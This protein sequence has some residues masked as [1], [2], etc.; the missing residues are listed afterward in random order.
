MRVL[1]KPATAFSQVGSKLRILGHAHSELDTQ[2]R[3]CF[4]ALGRKV[5]ASA[6]PPLPG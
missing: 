3:K 6:E 5:A 4:G 1:L 2:G